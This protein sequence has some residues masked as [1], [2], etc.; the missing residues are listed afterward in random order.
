MGDV[1]NDAMIQQHMAVKR[2][3]RITVCVISLVLFA[4][5][6]LVILWFVGRPML[7]FV[8]DPLQFRDWVDTHGF[9]GELVCIGMMALQ[10]IIAVIPGDPIEIGAGFVFGVWE[11][12]LLCVIGAFIGT[13]VSFLFTRHVGLKAVELF[14]SQEK[15]MSLT[16]L[17]NTKRLYLITLIL[18][19]IPGT[20]K[21]FITYFAGLTPMR[22]SLVLLMS[23]F[24][25]I[26]SILIYTISG[27]VL[28]LQNFELAIPLFASSVI[29][30]VTG[31]LIYKKFSKKMSQ[32]NSA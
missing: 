12:T 15:I 16:F 3:Q 7:H 10:I 25:R 19:L 30:S 26:P 8:S 22:F 6:S 11:G 32:R 2:R 14:Y 1:K 29:L 23:G 27:N 13:A 5:L 9:W 21:D 28:G 20:P 18:F 17:Q 4:I 24:G 31:I